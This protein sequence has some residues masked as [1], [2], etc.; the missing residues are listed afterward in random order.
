MRD[1]DAFDRQR[2]DEEKAR[3]CEEA[4]QQA[5]EH[6]LR[7]RG[8]LREVSKDRE[9][10]G[11]DRKV[12]NSPASRAPRNGAALVSTR[13]SMVATTMRAGISQRGGTATAGPLA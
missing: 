13:T 5:A 7:R 6:A 10:S 11:K 2:D 9:H 1:A 12:A 8:P 4:Q 3:E